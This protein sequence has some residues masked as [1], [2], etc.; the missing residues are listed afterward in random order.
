MTG[1]LKATVTAGGVGLFDA[2]ATAD[3]SGVVRDGYLYG[4]C[5]VRSP[6]GD[7]SQPLDPVPVPAGQV[8]NPLL[9][10]NKLRDVRPGRRWLVY[11]VNPLADALAALGQGL[12]KQHAGAAVAGMAARTGGREPLVAEVSD[13]P[14]PLTRRNDKTAD[15]WVIEYRGESLTAKTWVAVTDGKVLRQE[16]AGQGETLRLE[17]ED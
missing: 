4:H 13:R 15:C 6:L 1:T 17:R 12:L 5:M 8:L 9:P 10:V 7:V 14:E 16:A 3:V 2:T 11:E